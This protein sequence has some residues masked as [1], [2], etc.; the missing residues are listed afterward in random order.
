MSAHD[1]QATLAAGATV[2]TSGRRGEE[3]NHGV[4]RGWYADA[5]CER[6]LNADPLR[7]DQELTMAMLDDAPVVLPRRQTSDRTSGDA[8]AACSGP[9]PSAED[10]SLV[11]RLRRR[12]AG[13]VGRGGRQ[14][15]GEGEVAPRADARCAVHQCQPRCRRANRQG[16][17]SRSSW[18]RPSSPRCYSIAPASRQ[19]QIDGKNG[20]NDKRR[21][22]RFSKPT[23][24]SRAARSTPRL[25]ERLAAT[26]TDP[27]IVEYEIQPADVKGP[28]NKT[29]PQDVG[30]RGRAEDTEFHQPA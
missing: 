28:F 8:G 17:R 26:S 25:R 24:S 10:L 14:V 2:W 22:P 3:E 27:A 1:V 4:A 6:V 19:G 16:T 29:G 9:P 18:R 20:T 12:N 30:K 15:A 5:A 21:S 23:G 13:D 11:L 7:R